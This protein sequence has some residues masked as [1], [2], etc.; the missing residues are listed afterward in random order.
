MSATSPPATR[1]VRLRALGVPVDLVLGGGRTE[2]LE[3]AVRVAWDR[4]LAGPQAEYDVEP[5]RLTVALEDQADVSAPD[6]P[7]L[8]H[9]LSMAVNRTVSTARAGGLLMLHAATLAHPV[10]GRTAALA[11]RSG[12]GKTT[13]CRTLGTRL[14]Y[15]SDEIAGITADG[16]MVAYPKPLSVLTDDGDWR[17]TQSSPTALGLLEPPEHC[18]LGAVLLLERSPDGPETPEAE[19]L[20]RLESLVWLAEQ[21]FQL[22]AYERPL[23]M[24]ADRLDAV[25]GA[26]RVRYREAAALG[27]LIDDLL[28]NV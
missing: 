16:T 19:P 1:T 8:L 2:E 15:L 18:R 17:K 28:G 27:P 25:G 3:E 10:T 11:A 26:M 22:P 6:V 23:H 20:E 5:V 14:G 7:T 13:L 4:C 24:L 21:T 9:H 12:T